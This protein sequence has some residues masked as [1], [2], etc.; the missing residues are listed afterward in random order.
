MRLQIDVH[1]SDGFILIG[2][3]VVDIG[4]RRGSDYLFYPTAGFWEVWKEHRAE[5]RARG[6]RVWKSELGKWRGELSFT[7]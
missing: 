2:G 4:Q 6:V 7:E 3:A 5:L 1:D